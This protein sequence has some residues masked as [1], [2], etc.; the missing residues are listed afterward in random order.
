MVVTA[1]LPPAVVGVYT[2]VIGWPRGDSRSIGAGQ[3]ICKGVGPG[4][5]GPPP[6]PETSMDTAMQK[7]ASL[8]ACEA[9][10]MIRIMKECEWPP[11]G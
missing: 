2:T 11:R 5:M 6:H 7:S 4:P 10:D 8:N 1:P 9:A 3:E